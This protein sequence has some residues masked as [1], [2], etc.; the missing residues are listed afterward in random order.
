[1]IT[2]HHM[3][4]ALM[5][6]LIVCSSF[7]LSDPL[8]MVLVIAGT[9]IG[10]LLPDIHMTPPKRF[11][12]R[13]LAWLIVQF[14]R[15]VCSPILCR[16]YI[17]T[18]YPVPDPADKR[19]THS[20]PGILFIFAFASAFLYIPV[21]LVDS[22]LAGWIAVFLGGVLLGMGLHLVEDLCTRKG[23]FPFFPFSPWTISGS[24]RPCD[25]TDPRIARYHIQ[26]CTVLIVLFWLESAGILAPALFLPISVA[27]ITFCL[28]T[29][30]Y[31]SEVSV[32]RG[33]GLA[34]IIKASS[35][36]KIT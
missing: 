1:M 3:A 19:L 26:H 27:G 10:V 12:F 5:C 25:R 23:I 16:I 2:R 33:S 20:I 6:A 32:R 29:M 13:T 4:L 36:A 31:F 9:C 15:Q 22:A 7:F 30:V 34:G 11:T 35:P 24:I 8:L 21:R 14:P 17:H 18:R 28:G